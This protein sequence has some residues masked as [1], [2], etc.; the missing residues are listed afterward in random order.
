MYQYPL[1]EFIYYEYRLYELVYLG[2]EALNASNKKHE[3]KIAAFKK[4]YSNR[5]LSRG[6]CQKNEAILKA[7]V[8]FLSASQAAKVGQSEKLASDDHFKMTPYFNED[9]FVKNLIDS[10]NN[11]FQRNVVLT[12]GFQKHRLQPISADAVKKIKHVN[13]KEYNSLLRARAIHRFFVALMVSL[14]VGIFFVT[15][16]L[17][18]VLIMLCAIIVVAIRVSQFSNR[19]SQYELKTQFNADQIIYE[20]VQARK[21]DSNDDKMVREEGLA[22]DDAASDNLSSTYDTPPPGYPTGEAFCFFHQPTRRDT[23]SPWAATP[24]AAR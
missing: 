24:G 7:D 15:S 22:A 16:A 4:A 5:L 14:S 9:A 1:Y 19:L 23:D 8:A 21:A 11:D 3:K 12:I 6:L 13:E 17:L 18:A 10:I 2:L 20:E